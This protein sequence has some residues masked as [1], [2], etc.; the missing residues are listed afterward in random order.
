MPPKNKK[1][2]PKRASA[3]TSVVRQQK[4]RE[5]REA[6]PE[7]IRQMDEKER[8]R[9][10]KLLEAE[11]KRIERQEKK[12]KE[13]RAELRERAKTDPEAAKEFDALKA[14]EAEARKRKKEREEARMA[15]DPEYAAMMA[16]RKAEY[17]RA[18]TARR[19]AQREAL[20]ELAKTDEEAARKLAEMRKYQC[21]ATLRSRQKMVAD[22]EAGDPEAIARYE[23]T[24]AKRREKMIAVR[25]LV[26]ELLLADHTR[27]ASK[28]GDARQKMRFIATIVL[29]AA[30]AADL[31]AARGLL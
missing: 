4:I 11:R 26:A 19:K 3:A 21:E 10:E 12:R 29:P 25:H 5:A 30:G 2:K 22:A 20:V 7:Y 9:Q 15:A 16:E 1:L 31:H 14:R 24:L 28:Q 17:T 8:I 6:D 18:R 23:A 13:T 27:A